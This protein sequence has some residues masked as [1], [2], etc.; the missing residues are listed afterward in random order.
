M[1]KG[2][3]ASKS[4]ALYSNC[5]SVPNSCVILDSF[6]NLSDPQ[7]P[8]LWNEDSNTHFQR[9]LWGLTEPPAWCAQLVEALSKHSCVRVLT[10]C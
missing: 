5:G 7:F 2:D 8:H 6:L 1:E 9:L 4:L 10:R 3:Q